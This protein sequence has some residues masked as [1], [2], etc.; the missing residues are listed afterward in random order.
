MMQQ[1]PHQQIN[2][3][4]AAT[5]HHTTPHQLSLSLSLYIYIYI[6]VVFRVVNLELE[7]IYEMFVQARLDL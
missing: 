3:D 1:P 6:K 5:P 4:A 2:H 7:S